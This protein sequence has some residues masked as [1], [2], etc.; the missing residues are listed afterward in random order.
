M[1]S[2]YG[3]GIKYLVS[4]KEKHKTWYHNTSLTVV[5]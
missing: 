5:N 2:G 3:Y 1:T 4:A